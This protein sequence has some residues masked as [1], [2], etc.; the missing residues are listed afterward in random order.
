[1]A[2]LTCGTSYGLSIFFAFTFCNAFIVALLSIHRYKAIRHPLDHSDIKPRHL[3]ACWVLGIIWLIPNMFTFQ[4]KN[5]LCIREFDSFHL[6]GQI[7]KVGMLMCGMILPIFVIAVT[8][9]LTI[10]A[11]VRRTKSAGQEFKSSHEA[12]KAMNKNKRSVTKRLTALVLIAIIS[13]VPFGLF[14]VIDMVKQKSND[15]CEEHKLVFTYKCCLLYTSPS[16]R[17]GLLSRMPSSA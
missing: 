12:N 10:R 7:Y 15:P 3:F 16:P 5:A 17:D 8:H 14:Y 6:L 4:Y 9:M 13:W 2:R 1:M 11:L